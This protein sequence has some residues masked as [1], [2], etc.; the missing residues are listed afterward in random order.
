M[1]I[2]SDC[3]SAGEFNAVQDEISPRRSGG[4]AQ[5]RYPRGQRAATPDNF[6]RRPPGDAR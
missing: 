6:A 4:D 3:S 1:V 5:L 2:T